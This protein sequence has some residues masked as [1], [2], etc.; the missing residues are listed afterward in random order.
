[1]EKKGG[2]LNLLR[3]LPGPLVPPPR[4]ASPRE[5]PRLRGPYVRAA[6]PEATAGWLLDPY[7]F[8]FKQW[9]PIVSLWFP[10]SFPMVSLWFPYGFP[11]VS[12]WFPYGFP[13]VSLCFLL[14][15]FLRFP[16]GF[17]MVSL[18]F[19][20]GFPMVS[21]WFPYVFFVFVLRFPYG[22]LRFHNSLLLGSQR[23]FYR[24]P[25]SAQTQTPV[26][27]EGRGGTFFQGTV[28]FGS[29]P[30]HT[31]PYYHQISS[32]K[33]LQD[34]KTYGMISTSYGS[35]LQPSLGPAIGSR[36]FTPGR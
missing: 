3:S 36:S 20:Y 2:R 1:M 18:W 21:L 19:P 7:G 11:M 14:L 34:G 15:L 5:V 6:E 23:F 4:S 35:R 28:H 13:M 27:G 25:K 9:I 33:I 22:S 17:P 26:E 31:N 16:Y 10:Y 8:P 32:F 30:F 24:F 29:P 12:L